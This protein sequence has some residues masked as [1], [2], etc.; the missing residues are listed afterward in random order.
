[1]LQIKRVQARYALLGVLSL[2]LLLPLLG[3]PKKKVI[4]RDLLCQKGDGQNCLATG[5]QNKQ[6]PTA[7]VPAYD[8][9][10]GPVTCWRFVSK[11]KAVGFYLTG[12]TNNPLTAP[13]YH[14]FYYDMFAFAGRNDVLGQGYVGI[15]HPGGRDS[16]GRYLQ[17]VDKWDQIFQHLSEAGWLQ[18]RDI[19]TDEH[20]KRLAQV[21]QDIKTF[22]SSS[23]SRAILY[24]PPNKKNTPL[25]L[26][27]YTVKDDPIGVQAIFPTRYLPTQ[28][29]QVLGRIYYKQRYTSAKPF[30]Q[31]LWPIY[32]KN[33]RLAHQI[34]E[35]RFQC[36]HS[37]SQ[38]F[39]VY[40]N[41]IQKF[42][43]RLSSK[44][45][46]K[47]NPNII[48]TEFCNASN[49]KQFKASEPIRQ[50]IRSYRK[51]ID[52]L[53][54]SFRELVEIYSRGL[55]NVKTTKELNLSTFVDAFLRG[56]ILH[57][58]DPVL[59]EGKKTYPQTLIL[60]SMKSTRKRIWKSI[61]KS[62]KKQGHHIQWNQ[63]LG[64][65]LQEPFTFFR[66]RQQGTDY[67]VRP[68]H[69]V[70]GS[71]AL[72]L[73]RANGMIQVLTPH[74][75]PLRAKT[76]KSTS[77]A[78][79]PKPAQKATSSSGKTSTPAESKPPFHQVTN[80]FYR[81]YS[82]PQKD[83]PLT[84]QP[85]QS[86]QQWRRT[87]RQRILSLIK[88]PCPK[89]APTTPVYHH[90]AEDLP[91]PLPEV[92][93]RSFKLEQGFFFMRLRCHLFVIPVKGKTQ[94]PRKMLKSL[95]RK[96]ERDMLQNDRIP[97]RITINSIQPPQLQF[98]NQR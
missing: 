82:P 15:L 97:S 36:R 19:D 1:M 87:P 56:S 52:A 11:N 30:L 57:Y 50:K 17:A 94:V 39:H 61:H 2:T 18:L 74:Q 51:Q 69:I 20:K 27:V 65:I 16:S 59:V 63:K 70:G 34:H 83:F 84:T 77:P 71:F 3:C 68:F 21:R 10:G 96:V 80:A 48:R 4:N 14:A 7:A 89:N 88:Q 60:E 37:W 79:P 46:R 54:E 5:F 8:I 64:G 73:D 91:S 76:S 13:I 81:G 85:L 67:L 49:L 25:F 58:E 72:L 98:H 86:I 35:L 28:R 47:D 44:F 92:P 9:N 12:Q 24:Y 22:Y 93:A 33:I 29:A 55:D 40:N 90:T 26:P 6:S 38:L 95:A 32:Q 42:S 62:L 45:R 78:T 43:F 23:S 53:N 31:A 75:R 66:V 41:Q